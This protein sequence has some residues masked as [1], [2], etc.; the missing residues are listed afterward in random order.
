M[1]VKVSGGLV[2]PVSAATDKVIGVLQNKPVPGDVCQI[3]TS[4]ISRMKSNDATITIGSELYLDVAGMATTTRT[5]SSG[6]VGIAM[7][8]AAAGSG[9]TIAVFLNPLGTYLT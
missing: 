2:V 9:F 6:S 4:G 8:A 7:E 5:G 3:M 1:A